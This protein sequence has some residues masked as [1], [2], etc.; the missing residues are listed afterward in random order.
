MRGS[1][2]V[3]VEQVGPSEIRG[4][5]RTH[6]ITIDRP[7]SKGGTDRGPLGGEYLLLGLAGCFLSTLLAAIRARNADIANVCVR[8]TGVLDGTPERLTEATLLVS[9]DGADDALLPRLVTI[10]EAACIVTNTLRRA[11]DISV[12]VE[13]RQQ[14]QSAHL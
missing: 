9:A 2:T 8:A 11:A 7:V 5:A 10:A 12:V 6:E 14:I 13:P 3:S 4:I 1:L